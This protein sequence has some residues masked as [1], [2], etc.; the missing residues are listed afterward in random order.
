LLCGFDP[1]SLIGPAVL[2]AC[3]TDERAV[4]AAGFVFV[5]WAIHNTIQQK[6]HNIFINVRSFSVMIGLVLYLAA[7]LILMRIYGIRSFTEAT[8]EF[9]LFNQINN[10]PMGIWT[11]L[12]G[13]W[14]IVLL[15][16]GTLWS[17][18]RYLMFIV[19]S[20]L[21]ILQITGALAVVDITRSMAYLLP[22][23]FVAVAILEKET[24]DQLESFYLLSTIVR[25]GWMTYYAG[26]K[27]SIWLFYP[28]PVQ[29]IRW[30][31]L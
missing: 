18:K 25:I 28:L 11:A 1:P 20:L 3:F 2:L 4:I 5:W 17:K 30:F 15:A 7:R 31:F 9:Q 6:E 24:N 13:G 19:F 10:A 21:M 27:S 16:L 29:L 23:L 8:G 22:A 26:G 14:F 12:E